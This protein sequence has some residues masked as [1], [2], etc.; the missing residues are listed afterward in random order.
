MSKKIEYE[1]NVTIIGKEFSP[2]TEERIINGDKIPAHDDIF[3]L[4][5]MGGTTR[6]DAPELYDTMPTV[7]KVEVDKMDYLRVKSPITLKAI[8]R[9]NNSS[10]SV[11]KLTGMNVIKRKEEFDEE[12]LFAQELA[13]IERME[14]AAKAQEK[15]QKK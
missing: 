7:L 9:Q 4:Y 3:L 12:E 8:L 1:S 13:E 2:K 5:V 11:V 6:S 14:S 10:T 15:S